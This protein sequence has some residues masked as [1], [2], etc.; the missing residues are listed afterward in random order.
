VYE[1]E[2]LERVVLS[3]DPAA[4]H[5]RSGLILLQKKNMVRDFKNNTG[6]NER[7]CIATTWYEVVHIEVLKGDYLQQSDQVVARF[8]QFARWYKERKIYLDLLIDV[9]GVGVSVKMT[10][11]NRAEL[12]GIMI[13]IKPYSFVS[14]I[15]PSSHSHSI[16][17]LDKPSVYEFAYRIAANGQLKIHTGLPLAKELKREME[18][19]NVVSS[20][21]GRPL[22]NAPQGE[23]DDLTTSVVSALAYMDM[24]GGVYAIDRIPGL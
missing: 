8:A 21:S 16:L 15:Q 7:P 23:F 20:P 6:F 13:P 18:N 17:R 12:A 24:K 4:Y 1:Y 5:D 11:R 22:I 19:L 14:S 3:W 10:L 9:A 2:K